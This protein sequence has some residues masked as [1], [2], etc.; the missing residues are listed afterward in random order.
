M[1]LNVRVDLAHRASSAPLTTMELRLPA[2]VSAGS[3]MLGTA[4][5]TAETLRL[6]G[7]GGCSP[8]ALTGYGSAVVVV[9]LGDETITEHVAMTIVMAPAVE[10]QWGCTLVEDLRDTRDA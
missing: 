1:T 2:G 8:N 10:E 5:C 3:S 7:P 9:P 4:T 6:K